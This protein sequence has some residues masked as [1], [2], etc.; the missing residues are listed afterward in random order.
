[1][2]PERRLDRILEKGYLLAFEQFGS[3]HPCACFSESTPAH[4][5]YL[6]GTGRFSPW[7]LVFDRAAVLRAGGGAV[8]Y[9]PTAVQ[10]EFK[11]KGLGHWAVRTD[12]G[13]TWMHEREW[14]LPVEHPSNI[15][16]RLRSARAI[17]IGRPDWRPTSV[18]I[19]SWI[20]RST[21]EPLPD[22]GDNPYAEQLTDLPALWKKSEIWVWDKA[23]E[24]VEKYPP[25][26]LCEVVKT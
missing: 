8:A 1:M 26:T 10:K 16:F 14:R 18:K 25:G 23:R 19:D 4:L 2:T 24:N 20:D 5:A 6:I 11:S 12:S 15:G 9:V 7:G 21:G 13:S 3:N 22:P 17:L